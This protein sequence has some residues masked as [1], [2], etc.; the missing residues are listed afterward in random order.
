MTT[1]N[2]IGV[3]GSSVYGSRRSFEFCFVVI[4]L[5]PDPHVHVIG[6]TETQCCSHSRFL[7]IQN[8]L[9]SSSGMQVSSDLFYLPKLIQSAEKSYAQKINNNKCLVWLRKQRNVQ[10]WIWFSDLKSISLHM[11]QWCFRE[12]STGLFLSSFDSRIYF[13]LNVIKK[14]QHFQLPE[15]EIFPNGT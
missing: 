5:R 13:P 10:W 3:N 2:Q 8:V 1:H 15:C 11:L 9:D 4:G 6:H 12:T 7:T 14:H